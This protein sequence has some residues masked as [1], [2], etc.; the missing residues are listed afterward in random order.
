L[1]YGY[2]EEGYTE[3]G[4]IKCTDFD[5]NGLTAADRR[6][7]GD[8]N[9][10]FIY[11]L[12]SLMTWKGFDFSFFIQGSQGND[13]FNVV[14]LASTMDFAYAHNRPKDMI[15]NTWTAA[16]TTTKYPKARV[17]APTYFSDRWVED[18]SYMKLKNI[19]LG[20]TLPIKKW[21]V[22]WMKRA[23]LYVSGQNLITLTKYSGFDPEVNYT[24][25][26]VSQGIDYFT[27]SMPSKSWT[28]GVKLEF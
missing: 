26:S 13:L 23:Q 11:G 27:Y 19:Q 1:F 4:D 3:T 10:D 17:G 24:G 16:N 25:S 12:N 22:N 20:Y 28:F 15:N 5:G 8:P 2:V 7:I 9:P 21:N 6:V 18:G 14:N